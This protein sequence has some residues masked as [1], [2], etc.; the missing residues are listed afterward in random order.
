[1]DNK[2]LHGQPKDHLAPIA[3]FCYNRPVHLKRVIDALVENQ[4]ASVSTLYIFC[5]GSKNP[6]DHEAV[7]VVRRI[8]QDATGF[9]RIEVRCSDLNL[10]LAKSIISGV[11]EV[12]ERHGRV[13]VLEDD[14]VTSPYFLTY[15][16]EALAMYEGVD[17]V[18][19]IHGYLYPI[20]APLPETFFLR[21]ADCWGWATWSRAWSQF[22]ADGTKLLRRLLESRQGKAF[23]LGGAYPY[24]RMLEDQ[25]AGR[26]D[27]WAIRWHASVFLNG[28]LTLYPG[29]SLVLNIGLDSTGTHS[30]TTNSFGGG[31]SN[32]PIQLHSVP[33]E[34]SE[35]G[36]EAFVSFFRRNEGGRLRHF[37][38][39]TLG[40]WSWL[41][42][43][44]M[45]LK[46]RR[47]Q[48]ALRQ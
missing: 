27:S 16:N 1:M 33:I 25:I 8:A 45:I 24:Q 42:V 23:D 41:R 32:T 35:A 10:G 7:S 12:V 22:E 6:T 4:L 17:T 5:D 34:P 9:R 44:L 29:R 47:S 48:T 18:A 11:S 2:N 26:N 37:F 30:R 20:S 15:M 40:R 3:L 28:G 14:L 38:R 46:R 39:R 19:S 21:G 43:A 13:I 31:I 36:L